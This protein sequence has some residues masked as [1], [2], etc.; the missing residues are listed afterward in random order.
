MEKWT[1]WTP[2]FLKHNNC[3][4]SLG[5]DI[6]MI[7]FVWTHAEEQLKLLHKDLY[8]SHPNLNYVRDI[9]E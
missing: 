9:S 4:G 3:S 1:K 5:S 8:E 6:L 7:F 2:F